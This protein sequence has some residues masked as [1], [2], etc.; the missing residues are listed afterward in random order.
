ME[1]YILTRRRR[2]KSLR[3]RVKEDGKV[4]VSAPY[5]VSA[6]IIDGFVESRRSW[7]AEQRR[8]LSEDAQT[9]KTELSDG[10]VITVLGRTY[11]ICAFNGSGCYTEKGFLFVGIPENGGSADIE[12]AVMKFMAEKCRAVCESALKLYLEKSGYSGE[13]PLLRLRLMKSRWGS[14]NRAKNVIT[15]NSALCKLSEE[16]INYVAAH[17]VAHI[18]VPNHS[19]DFYSFGEKIYNGFYETDRRLNKIKISGIFA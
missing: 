18:F 12:N 16:Y 9:R 5:G 3:L 1:N 10:D 7:I 13:K 15:L 11:I 2:M 6:D 17:E 4:Y 14:Y 19:A 8:K